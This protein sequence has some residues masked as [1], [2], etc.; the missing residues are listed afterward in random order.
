M[1]LIEL[2]G[3]LF[4]FIARTKPV[5]ESLVIGAIMAAL[6]AVWSAVNSDQPLSGRTVLVICLAAAGNY[7]TSRARR[8]YSK[9][10][11]GEA[12]RATLAGARMREQLHVVGQ[13]RDVANKVAE[14]QQARLDQLEGA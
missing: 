8:T 4:N 7:L 14:K 3:F 9:Q 11:E 12:V 10:I 13:E 6:E 5:I 1:S 2:K